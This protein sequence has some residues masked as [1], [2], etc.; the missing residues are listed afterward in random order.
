MTDSSP[1]GTRGG[2]LKTRPAAPVAKS[3]GNGHDRTHVTTAAL[4][5][6]IGLAAH[7]VPGV[8]GMAPTNLGEG[9]RRILGGSQAREGVEIHRDEDDPERAEAVLHVV[10]AYGVNIPVVAESVVQRVQY[11][12]TQYAGVT[13]RT[14]RVQVAGVSRA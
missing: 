9:L 6:L 7:E 10:V 2:D 8:V 3:A 14:V 12:A 5:T 11:A 1:P 4:A 13:L